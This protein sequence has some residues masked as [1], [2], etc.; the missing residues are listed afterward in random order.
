MPVR[1]RGALAMREKS[2]AQ[3]ATD[4]RFPLK[5]MPWNSRQWASTVIF[6]NQLIF[7]HMAPPPS[8]LGFLEHCLLISSWASIETALLRWGR[9]RGKEVTHLIVICWPRSEGFLSF[10]GGLSRLVSAL[11]VQQQQDMGR[12]SDSTPWGL[13]AEGG[14]LP[15]EQADCVR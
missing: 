15:A 7:A 6:T 8:L 2:F 13:Q 9:S 14:A 11:R 12:L 5:A 10:N 1:C 4:N 3:E